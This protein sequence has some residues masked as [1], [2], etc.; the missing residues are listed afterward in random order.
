LVR[1]PAFEPAACGDCSRR[2]SYQVD[3]V[4]WVL[5]PKSLVCPRRAREIAV[6]RARH[7]IRRTRSAA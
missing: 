1:R 2:Q 4:R 6:E 3:A 5:P 7:S